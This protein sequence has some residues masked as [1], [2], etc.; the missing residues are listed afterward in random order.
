MPAIR[1]RNTGRDELSLQLLEAAVEAGLQSGWIDDNRARALVNLSRRPEA[2]SLWNGLVDHQDQGLRSI[3]EEMLELQT[4]DRLLE[5]REQLIRICLEQGWVAQGLNNTFK[6][7]DAL[8]EAVLQ[9]CIHARE[10]GQASTS[11]LLIEAS[12]AA[13]MQSPWLKDNLARALVNLERLPEAVAL[14]RELEAL[15]EQDALAG[16]ASEMLERY[17]GKADRLAA[18]NKAQELIDEGQI[19]QAKTLLLRAMLVDPTWDGYTDKLIQLL[20]I[21]RGGD[22]DDA[23]LLKR[24]L[25][26]D[27]LN[28]E[29]FDEY[30]DLVEERLKDAAARSST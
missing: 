18:T 24:E 21:E 7:M 22:K 20:K 12:L 3:A 19:E 25:E 14:W 13:G 11:L 6:S 27:Q 10:T 26:E 28:L 23:D 8:E 9:E 30:L 5:L 4:M 16:M 15:P 17:A 1:F 2:I 29:A